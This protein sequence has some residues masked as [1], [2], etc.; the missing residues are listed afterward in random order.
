LTGVEDLPWLGEQARRLE[1]MRMQAV[2]SLVEAHLVLGEHALVVGELEQLIQDNPFHEHLHG[3]LML[4]LYRCGRQADALNRFRRL[5]RKLAEDLGIEPGPELRAL[6]AQIL[7]QDASLDAP[8]D[9]SSPSSDAPSDR[10]LPS[11]DASAPTRAMSASPVPA[12]LPPSV[13]T[14]AGRDDDLVRLNW[15]LGDADS[16]GVTIAVITGTA[17]VGK[18]ALATHWAHTVRDRFPDG[19]LYINLRGFDAGAAVE[20]TAAIRHFLD[21]FGV[22]ANRVPPDLSSQTGLYRSLLADKRVLVVL[23]NARDAEQVRPLLPGASGCHVVVTS[24]GQLTGLVAVEGARP[25]IL[26]LL[27]PEDARRMIGGRLDVE[28]AAAEPDAVDQLI[29]LCSR[30]PLALAVATARAATRPTFTLSS[31]AEELS[32]SRSTLGGWSAGDPA[33]DVRNVFSWSYLA[34]SDDAASLFRL[35]GSHPGPD[36]SV[37]AAASLY[38]CAS[39]QA[40]AML[41]ELANLHMLTEHRPG[42]Y[43]CHDLLRAY[44]GELARAEPDANALQRLLHYYLSSAHS[45][46]LRLAPHRDPIAIDVATNV[47]SFSARD[48][49]EAMAWFALERSNLLALATSAFDSGQDIHAWQLAWTLEPFLSRQGHV[50]DLAATQRIALAAAQRLGDGAMQARTHLALGIAALGQQHPWT[51]CPPAASPLTT[52][53]DCP[54]PSGTAPGGRRVQL[55]SPP[56]QVRPF[57]RNA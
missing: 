13:P 36:V 11:S 32:R 44:A 24:R 48:T 3:Q 16:S 8:L 55:T 14:F 33:S 54:T 21:A 15:T 25:V 9:R 18:S 4:A 52:A 28:Q 2:R 30:L 39:E 47:T 29:T 46:A 35:L 22:P 31:L 40:Q 38:G 12:Q 57:L 41:N 1:E 19:Q 20:P 17:G 27:T 43:T 56:R 23:D 51:R 5:R 53:L 37:A 50:A 34:L 10:S 6:E 49:A 45:A 26:D 42:R 7:R